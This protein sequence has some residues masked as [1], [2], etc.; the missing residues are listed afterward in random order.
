MNFRSFD[1][2]I[3][4]NIP[5]ISFIWDLT[6]NEIVHL[7]HGYPPTVADTEVM[8]MSEQERLLDY[9]HPDERT[10]VIKSFFLHGE[11]ETLKTLVPIIVNVDDASR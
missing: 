1:K 10:R 11:F 5:E 9:I 6:S 8:E 3:T 7:T 2:H 4:D